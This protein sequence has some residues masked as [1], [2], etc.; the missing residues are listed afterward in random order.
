VREAMQ[1][2]ELDELKKLTAKYLGSQS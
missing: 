1:A 2:N